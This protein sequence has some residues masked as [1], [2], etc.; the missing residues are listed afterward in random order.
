MVL[1]NKDYIRYKISVS[2]QL[3][4]KNHNLIGKDKKRG[5]KEKDREP[6][7]VYEL[8]GC[9]CKWCLSRKYKSLYNSKYNKSHKYKHID[10]MYDFTT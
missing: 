2:Y 7:A 5:L 9:R 6:L 10:D 3:L 1:K 8:H 4:G